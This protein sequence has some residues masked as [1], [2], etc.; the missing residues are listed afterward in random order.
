MW[1]KN[2]DESDNTLTIAIPLTRGTYKTRI[3]KR[4]FFN[5]YGLPVAT[6]RES[7]SQSCYVEWQIGYDVT[8]TD[9]AKLKLTTLQ[10]ECFIAANGQNKALYE[11]SEYIYYFYKWGILKK[12]P[13][14]QVKNFLQ[15][16]SE[17]DFIDNPDNFA[18]ERSQPVPKKVLDI[19]FFYS[20][21]KYPLLIHKFEP[22]E[23]LVE[24]K[25]SEKQYAIGVQPMLYFC[26]PITELKSD[27][28]LLGRSAETKEAADFVI[29]RKNIHIF[30]NMIK[31]FGI[32]SAN[33]NK[34]VLAI[35]D[36]ILS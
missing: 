2:I 34:D 12:I 33:H 27:R 26:F 31:I 19:D 21:V 4:S 9:I 17:S 25:I 23:I 3:K 32:L 24:I 22:Y 6:K 36:K 30:I 35:L 28:P 7:F 1:I 8:T 18:I 11:L 5:E 29:N 10:D 13:L 16:L 14:L 15:T 20:Q